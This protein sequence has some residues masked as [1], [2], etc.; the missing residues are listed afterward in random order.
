MNRTH[1]GAARRAR[2]ALSFALLLTACAAPRDEVVVER[3][4]RHRLPDPEVVTSAV[5]RLGDV[6]KAELLPWPPH[7]PRSRDFPELPLVRV[8]EVEDLGRTGA[9]VEALTRTLEH[10][11]RRQRILRLSIDE[12]AVP[13]WLREPAPT[14]ADQAADDPAADDATAG[15]AVG[16]AA[17]PLR[18]PERARGDDDPTK[19]GLRLKAW[20]DRAGRL[21]IELE[22]LVT[23]ERL[24][25]ARS[26]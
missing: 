19:P 10:E 16:E 18:T 6:V 8:E 26:R 2:A 21:R 25:R 7:L 11:L 14:A 20:T 9:D 5:R 17:P 13:T 4:R 1:L 24:T 12:E 15:D 22:D 23:G 3:D